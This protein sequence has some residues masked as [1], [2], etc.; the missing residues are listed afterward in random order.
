M[1]GRII[2]KYVAS[3]GD[4]GTKKSLGT[5]SN[6]FNEV[7]DQAP[8][9]GVKNTADGLH[10]DVGSLTAMW[11]SISKR[12]KDW[13]VAVFNTDNCCGPGGR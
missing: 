12:T 5:A 7:V 9:S 2:V 13:S 3:D 8:I 1:N 10:G 4:L 11:A 6:E